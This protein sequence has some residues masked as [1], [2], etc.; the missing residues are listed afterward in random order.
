VSTFNESGYRA[1][2]GAIYTVD[3]KRLALGPSDAYVYCPDTGV[4]EAFKTFRIGELQLDEAQAGAL[5]AH[6]SR[7]LGKE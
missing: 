7:W 3:D 1:T 4:P 5:H 6:L 2:W